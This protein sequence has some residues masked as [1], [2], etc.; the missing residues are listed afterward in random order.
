MFYKILLKYIYKKCRNLSVLESREFYLFFCINKR[1][2][3][4]FREVRRLGVGDFCRGVFDSVSCGFL[5]EI[6]DWLVV[7]LL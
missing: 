5:V 2:N 1:F 7:Y 4:G 3:I 6:V